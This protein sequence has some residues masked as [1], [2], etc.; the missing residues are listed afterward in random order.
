MFGEFSV[1]MAKLFFLL[2]VFI[3][4]ALTRDHSLASG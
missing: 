1:E 3:S 2:G 4:A